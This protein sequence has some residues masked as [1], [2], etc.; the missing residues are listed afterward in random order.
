MTER[1]EKHHGRGGEDRVEHA[2]HRQGDA[3]A[4]CSRRPRTD[5]GGRC[6]RRGAPG[7]ASR[8][9]RRGRCPSAPAERPGRRYRCREPRAM[10]RSAWARLGA[11]LTPSPI[12]AT[13][14]PEAC[15]RRMCSIFCSG[16]ASAIHSIGADGIGSAGGGG[17]GVAREQHGADAARA[18]GRAQADGFGTNRIAEGERTRGRRHPSRSRR[19]CRRVQGDRVG[20][21][22]A[23][24]T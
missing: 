16:V 11:S 14:A 5:S 12:M 17:A 13:R 21:R 24:P 1:L 23:C 2:G 15:R 8:P 6:G 20:R 4:R 22:T 18:Q 19:P 3:D 7:R 10:P 9:P